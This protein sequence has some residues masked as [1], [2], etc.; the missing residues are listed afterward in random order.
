MSDLISIYVTLLL[1][2]YETMGV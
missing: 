2:H 1:L